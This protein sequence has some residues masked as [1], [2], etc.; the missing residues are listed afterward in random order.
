VQDKAY[1]TTNQSPIERGIRHFRWNVSDNQ[2][3]R[4]HPSDSW[5]SCFSRFL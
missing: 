2:Y 1:V 5:D 4:H 3:G